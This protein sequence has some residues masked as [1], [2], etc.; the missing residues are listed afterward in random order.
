[1]NAIPK[2]TGLFLAATFLVFFHGTIFAQNNRFAADTVTVTLKDATERAIR[3]SPE[4]SAS[5]SDTKKAE[6]LYNFAK[7]NRFL[8]EFELT[9]VFSTS[10]AIS[11]PNNTPTDRLYLDPDVRND[12]ENVSLFSRVDVRA[13]QPVYTWGELSGNIRAAAYGVDV[14][15]EA[16][17]ATSQRVVGRSAEMYY[18]LLLTEAL[19]RVTEDAGKQ[20]DEAEDLIAELLEAGD[21]DVDEADLFDVQITKQEFLRGVVAVEQKMQTAAAALSRQM[22]LPEGTVVRTVAPVLKTA[23]FELMPLDHYHALALEHRSELA[24]LKAGR[25]A[26][27]E[28]VIVAKS[29][30]FPKLFI[31][32]DATYSFTQ[33]R[34][35]QLNPYVGDPFLARSLR[36]GV[37][38]KQKLNFSQTRARVER[39][40]YEEAILDSQGEA[41]Y[42]LILFE[43]ESAYRNVIISDAAV[44]ANAEALR[45]SKEWLRT[46]QVNFDLEIG[47]SQNLVR[48]VKRNLETLLA[49]FRARFDYNVAIL[50][51][52]AFT[53]TLEASLE[54]GI[55][56]E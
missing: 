1:M 36:A 3:V 11:N 48:V 32:A 45:I 20:V 28:L 5:R 14:K 13:I 22:I 34:H 50:R 2:S 9:S 19:F 40:R 54:N 30:Y 51:L 27:S 39:A 49:D 7:A 6:A 53:G 12:W 56:L 44:T 41:L 31:A 17:R 47:D 37:G 24:Q 26:R 4:M 43:V 38:I 15:E 35:R 55:F 16:V 8:S 42:Q 21:E 25:Q 33:N 29:E 23:T 18:N 10:P 46:E 52:L